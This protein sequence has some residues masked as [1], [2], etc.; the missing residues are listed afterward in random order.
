[1]LFKIGLNLQ[2]MDKATQPLR[3]FRQD[4]SAM[5]SSIT[6]VDTASARLR[7]TFQGVA[8]EI[9]GAVNE[10]RALRDQ[11][12]QLRSTSQRM[13]MG[14]VALAAAPIALGFEAMEFERGIAQISTLTDMTVAELNMR[15]SDELRAI[16]RDFG[17][18]HAQVLQ[19]MYNAVSAGIDPDAA[20]GFLR[21][22]A[23]A[24]IAGVSD[25]L[26]A[27]G[28]GVTVRNAFSLP[29]EEVN[30]IYDVMFK[31][32]GVGVTSLEEIGSSFSL[33]GSS[34]ASAGVSLEQM[35]ATVALLT[36][37]G[38]P[39]ST[40]Y[41]QIANSINAL[42]SPGS[43]ARETFK[44]LGIEM[45][46]AVLRSNDLLGSFDVVRGAISHLDEATRADYISR[47]FTDKQSQQLF[48]NFSAMRDEFIS[49]SEDMMNA[50]GATQNAFDKM[51]GTADFEFKR[52]QSTFK[53]L[54]ITLGATVV[55]GLNMLMATLVSVLEPVALLAQEFPNLTGGVLALVAGIGGLMAVVGV[56]G[57]LASGVMQAW[58]AFK[59]L[60]AGVK[61]V[62]VALAANPI[63]LAAAAIAGAAYLIYRNWEPIREF[64]GNLWGGIKT[65]FAA[66]WEI[67]KA[68]FNWHPLA[69]L[70]SNWE[71]IKSF[72]GG[73]WGGIKSIASGALEFIKALFMW[74][75]LGLV[76]SN[77]EPIKAFYGEL[78][79]GI[80][81]LSAGTWEGI[82]TLLSWSPLGILMRAWEPAKEFV[83]NLF[84]DP[85]N[86]LKSLPTMFYE[87]GANIVTSIVDGMKS[88]AAA[89]VEAIKNIAGKVRDFLP[90]SPAKDGPLR[91]LDQVRIVETFADEMRPEPAIEAIRNVTQHISAELEQ[92][93]MPAPIVNVTPAA[94]A[95]PDMPAINGLIS[96]VTNGL[97]SF[98]KAPL[99][100][101]IAAVKAISSTVP[102]ST[103][104]YPQANAQERPALGDGLP[105]PMPARAGNVVLEYK[106]TM[107]FNGIGEAQQQSFSEQ[108]ERHKEDIRRMLER[109]MEQE[110]RLAF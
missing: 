17:Q 12:D 35:Q 59:V 5:R 92:S 105:V 70:I 102:G 96:A 29:A 101:L 39:T 15:Y 51:A 23:K 22:S 84:T 89:P 10:T 56:F 85:L 106:P 63:V 45:N 83:N 78:W 24:G 8:S 16:S 66:G 55:P 38:V 110:E 52:M 9:R 79:D 77:W 62:S 4:V 93:S 81:N 1:M 98:V 26:A 42:Q 76:I 13:I 60:W 104:K 74:S 36:K 19:A 46:A 82:K 86:T 30:K 61:A 32:L 87:A 71:P 68:G 11:A 75:P 7:T 33:A 28:L 50:S 100:V 3:R 108:L 103:N 94:M 27:G 14:G 99:D 47:I 90:F 80:K 20:L 88:M 64:F 40:A 31:T 34:A 107:H 91:D 54:R 97:I 57:F 25:I 53:D 65:Y 41:I 48:L 37:V 18:D 95:M 6:G 73:F 72:F 58:A 43:Q 67:I 2:L 69:V 109:M 21:E 44:E 49:V